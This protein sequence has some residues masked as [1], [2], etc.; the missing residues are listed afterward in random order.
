M[1]LR[2]QPGFT[3]Y[4]QN[5]T[6]ETWELVD[7]SQHRHFRNFAFSTHSQ[8]SHYDSSNISWILAEPSEVPSG[9]PST[10]SESAI[11]IWEVAIFFRPSARTPPTRRPLQPLVQDPL[12]AT[13]CKAYKKVDEAAEGNMSKKY[14]KNSVL[15]DTLT[16]RT[17][18]LDYRWWPISM[19]SVRTQC[20]SKFSEGAFCQKIQN[21]NFIRI[22]IRDLGGLT[23]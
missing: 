8:E 3:Y 14:S 1:K 23:I 13:P 16:E 19:T 12:S 10:T 18:N 7:K 17:W 20:L 4:N 22:S 21:L 6:R 9:T 15:E 5:T 11:K 2:V